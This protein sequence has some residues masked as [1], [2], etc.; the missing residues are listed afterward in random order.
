[1]HWADRNEL[2]GLAA[3]VE[4]LRDLPALF[5]L[6]TRHEGDPIDAAWLVSAAGPPTRAIDLRPLQ[7]LDARKL[8]GQLLGSDQEEALE[9]CVA[10]SQGNPLFLE[11]LA[12]YLRERCDDDVPVSIQTVIQARL[13]LVEPIDRNALRAASILGQRFA[14]PALHAVL[15]QAN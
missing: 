1:M 14:L 13:D 3:L 11:Q 5:V 15:G 8:A 6:T 10:R 2:G 4:A 12:K 7:D 9:R